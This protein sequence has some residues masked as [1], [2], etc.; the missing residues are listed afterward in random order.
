MQFPVALQN[1]RAEEYLLSVVQLKNKAFAILLRVY[2]DGFYTSLGFT[3]EVY[4]PDKPL[5]VDR[6]KGNLNIYVIFNAAAAPVLPVNLY[7]ITVH[8][9]AYN[10][11]DN[12]MYMTEETF[13]LKE[14][15]WDV[16][17]ELC[18]QDR[19]VDKPVYLLS[20]GSHTEYVGIQF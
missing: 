20:D 19:P 7:N 14:I 8:R 15:D 2:E 16:V 6:A 13:D 9:V 18:R 1:S 11:I 3:K 17:K 4:V 12:K 5:R 10:N